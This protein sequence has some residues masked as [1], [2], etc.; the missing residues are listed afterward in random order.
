MRVL[1]APN[2]VR[3]REAPAQHFI[4]PGEMTGNV[5]A[6][7]PAIGQAAH[8]SPVDAEAVERAM[9]IPPKAP[10]S[11]AET[12]LTINTLLNLL[13]KAI[14]VTGEGTVPSMVGR[15]LSE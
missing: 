12:G 6:V 5:R 10:R 13:I 1:Q 3:I 14:S 7:P 11:I 15:T 2:R 9:R 8:I 4:Q